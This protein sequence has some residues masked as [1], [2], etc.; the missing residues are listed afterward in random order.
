MSW[1]TLQT[2]C[3][4]PTGSAGGSS[5]RTLP[6]LPGEAGSRRT[7]A[8]VQQRSH[9]ASSCAL[10]LLAP[11]REGVVEG[12]LA[13]SALLD[14]DDGAALIDI[15][16]RHVEPG[17]LFQQLHVARAGGLDIRQPDQEEAVGD[18]DGKAR[19]RRAARLLVGLHQDARHVA[20]PAT[21][22]IRRQN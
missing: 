11:G 14:G 8:R 13:W 17:T 10:R 9:T 6:W 7:T 3:P 4:P 1:Q 21:R 22:E 15:D 12:A 16:Q 19:E 2:T 18:L 5:S 20:D